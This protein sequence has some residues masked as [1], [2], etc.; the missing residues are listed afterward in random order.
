MTIARATIQ[1]FWKL[2]STFFIEIFFRILPTSSEISRQVSK[3]LDDESNVIWN[4]QSL[5]YF[6][7]K[8][9]LNEI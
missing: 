1:N 7:I 6:N 9:A 5:N 8:T 4:I 2:S 3:Q